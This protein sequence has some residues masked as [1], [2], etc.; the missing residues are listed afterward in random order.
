[1]FAHN[2]EGEES[3]KMKKSRS[4]ISKKKKSPFSQLVLF[5]HV[6]SASP[7]FRTE[8]Y[9]VLWPGWPWGHGM[10]GPDVQNSTTGE[11]LHPGHPS[12][13]HTCVQSPCPVRSQHTNGIRHVRMGGFQTTPSQGIGPSTDAAV[14]K[15]PQS[16]SVNLKENHCA[17]AGKANKI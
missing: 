14:F 10:S 11:P 16:R 17:G 4:T 5:N 15:S 8:V 2:Y 9:H 6:Y 12:V 13:W 7:R 1:L 3:K